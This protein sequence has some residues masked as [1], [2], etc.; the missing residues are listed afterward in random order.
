MIVGEAPGKDED[1]SGQ[2]FS[3]GYGRV[4]KSLL[5]QGSVSPY[6]C[7][8][9]Y[10]LK[11][12][13]PNNRTAEIDE[14]Y[15]CQDH[16]GE[17]IQRIQPEYIV[18]L[19]DQVSSLLTG[20][21]TFTHRGSIVSGT[22]VASGYK[23]LITYDM[24]FVM[25]MQTTMQIVSWDLRQL[26][27]P[28][29]EYEIEYNTNPTRAELQAYFEK[30]AGVE[31]SVDIETRS[32]PDEGGGDEDALNPWRGNVIGIAFCSEPGK[33]IAMS[34]RT[35][36]DNW[37]LIT[38]FVS[39]T[40]CGWANNLF[41][42]TFLKV[43]HKLHLNNNWD[44]QDAIYLIHSALPKKLD[45][46]RSLYTSMEPYK[47]KYKNIY[48]K[49][50][51]GD[52]DEDSAN[53]LACCDV[54]CT[55]R[56]WIEQKKFV[57]PEH[58]KAMNEESDMAFQMKLN[59]VYIDQ[60]NVA[61]LYLDTLPQKEAL[62]NEFAQ[63]YGVS[64][65]SPKQLNDL[66]YK[67]FRFPKFNDK[68]KS[69]FGHA[70]T[71]EKAIQAIASAIGLVY[72]DDEDGE[73][74]EGEA[75]GGEVL[76]SILRYRGLAK[77]ISTYCE[78]VA[79]SI[80]SDGR[81]HPQ[82]SPNVVPTGRW[83]CR[84]VPMQGV[85]KHIRNIVRAAPGHILMGADYKGA[86]IMGAALLSGDTDLAAKMMDPL[87]SIHNEVLEAIRPHYPSIKKIQAKTVVFGVFFGRTEQ[88]IARAF[89]VPVATVKMWKNIFYAQRPLLK[90]FFEYTSPEYWKANGY[91]TLLDGRKAYCEKITEA[92]NYPVQ[93]FEAVMVKQA[94]R[95]LVAAGFKIIL[96]GHDQLV[97]EERK[98]PFINQRWRQFVDIL[99]TALPSMWDRFPIA[100]GMAE[101]WDQLETSCSKCGEEMLHLP[102]T[103]SWGCTKCGHVESD[104]ERYPV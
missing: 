80:E 96:N 12:K 62:S 24:P 4:L 76:A 84:G 44:V 35:M 14:V 90:E 28:R 45:F 43:Q 81:V 34:L 42:R 103:H 78:G 104:D 61:K 63:K 5:T 21:L 53:R 57:K 23:V 87:Y 26:V 82:W 2:A 32:Y 83:S 94:M 97:V 50:R 1:D 46:Q 73:R 100:G 33:A 91:V 27:Q 75:K 64:I 49:Y 101:Y 59:G 20:F 70:S 29:P 66:L 68:G 11:C 10:L 40:P 15:A 72:V 3:G 60:D 19:G 51:P 7:Y 17:E 8:F 25:K 30:Y 71:N 98:G 48:G 89:H 31:T 37:D 56:I 18:A 67:E 54:D 22:G 85:P 102:K 52:L 88:D 95:K 99:E 74:F 39:Q 55:K 6:N 41:D 86:Q 38:N 92:K 93:G 69:C 79:R 36:T 13:P 9:T 16:L 65:S 58:M 77:L 47:L